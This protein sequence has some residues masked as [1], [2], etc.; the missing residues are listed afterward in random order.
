MSWR[1]REQRKVILFPEIVQGRKAQINLGWG[2]KREECSCKRESQSGQRGREG[3]REKR[4]RNGKKERV[5]DRILCLQHSGK[6][7]S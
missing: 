4:D 2:G 7:F 3:E 5:W 6:Q 1:V